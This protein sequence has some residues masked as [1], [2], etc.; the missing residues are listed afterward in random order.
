MGCPVLKYFVGED[1]GKILTFTFKRHAMG[2]C[3]TV[4]LLVQAFAPYA[5]ELGD[6]EGR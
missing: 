3:R 2:N 5:L 4:K 1:N 6:F